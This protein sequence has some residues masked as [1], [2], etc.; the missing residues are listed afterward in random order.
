MIFLWRGSYLRAEYRIWNPGG[1]GTGQVL[2]FVKRRQADHPIPIF[3][4]GGFHMPKIISAAA[5]D[6]HTLTIALNNRHQS[7]MISGPGWRA[8]VSAAWRTWNGSR[9]SGWSTGTPWSGTVSARSRLMRLLI[10]LN[11]ENSG[12]C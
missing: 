1:G 7:S 11:G 6:D 3:Q 10:W 9:P 12:D 2:D 5:N 4:R 8:C